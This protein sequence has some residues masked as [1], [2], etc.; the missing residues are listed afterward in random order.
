MKQLDLFWD[1][2]DYQ[3]FRYEE[4]YGDW[5]IIVKMYGDPQTTSHPYE[6]TLKRGTGH[7]QETVADPSS[8]VSL[9][10]AIV[11]AI[12]AVE[13]YEHGYEVAKYRF[14]PGGPYENGDNKQ[15]IARS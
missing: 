3:N 11:M 14:S 9:D 8:H 7:R 15:T 4:Q 6:W 5:L 13:I 1:M 10:A 2:P 12:Y